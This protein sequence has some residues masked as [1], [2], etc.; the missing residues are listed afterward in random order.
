MIPIL[1]I[2]GKSNSGKTTLIENVIPILKGMGYRVGTIKHDA[3]RFDI[4]HEGKDSWRMA[5]AG[6]DTVVISSD[7][8]MAMV[9]KLD[10]EKN[11]DEM[12]DWLFG[13]VDMVIT[14][15]YKGSSKAKIEVIR[16]NIPVTSPD[17]HLVAV[18][19]NLVEGIPFLLSEDYKKVKFFQFGELEK[20]AGFIVEKCFEGREKYLPEKE[21]ALEA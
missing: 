14:E 2:V 20:I 18:V 12:V 16:Y 8:K 13:D 10:E 19:N 3:H 4:D 6:A 15:G 7:S 17:N 5:K 21:I 11:I 9:K 1:S